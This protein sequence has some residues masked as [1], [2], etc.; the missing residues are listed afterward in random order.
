MILR[1]E[2]R[3]LC[4][5]VGVGE[6]LGLRNRDAG[7][8]GISNQEVGINNAISTVRRYQSTCLV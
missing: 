8:Y 7:D 4:D 5:S 1:A 2:G 3:W 6:R